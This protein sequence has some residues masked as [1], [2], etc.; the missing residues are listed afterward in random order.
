MRTFIAIDLDAPLKEKLK[1]F[2]L[3]L[4]PLA[5]NV[6]WVQAAG[7]HL[8]LRFLGETPDE[9]AAAVD[10]ALRTIAAGSPRFLLRLRGMGAFPPG[11]SL[12]RVI[13]VGAEGGPPPAAAQKN[14]EFPPG[15]VG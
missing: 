13:W 6:R 14:I 9:K 7:M 3:E 12:P 8:T 4:A 15:G 11:R 5:P 10:R 1:S 2:V